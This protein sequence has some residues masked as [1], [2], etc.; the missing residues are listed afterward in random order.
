MTK[1]NVSRASRTKVGGKALLEPCARCG[2]APDPRGRPFPITF[3]LPDVYSEI[4]EEL[5]AAWGE[6]PFLAIKTIGFFVRVILPVKL[7]DGYSVDFGTWLEV[8]SEDFRTTW[9]TWNMPEYADLSIEGYVANAIE[10]W[11]KLPHTLVRATVRDIDQ[12]PY[13]TSCN[14]ERM[15]KILGDTWPHDEVLTPYAHLLKADP[16]AER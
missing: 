11:K 9:Q 2:I 7:T 15:S 1:S 12:V 4:P 10:P 13:L 6:D 8:H 3:E 5:L 16:P 14:D